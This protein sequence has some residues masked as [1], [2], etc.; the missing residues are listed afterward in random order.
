MNQVEQQIDKLDE[1]VHLSILYDFY[2]EL[3]NDHK[4]QIFE[5]YV[6]NDFSLS[7]IASEQGISRQGVYD[8]VKRCSQELKD[9]ESKLNLVRK[10]QSIKEKINNIKIRI[11]ETKQTGDCTRISEA[12]T[13]A[14]EILKEL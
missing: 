9:Y 10:F 2:G 4:K 13:L 8:I 14:D 12:D 7:E 6:L 1:I 5:D 3:L 11:S